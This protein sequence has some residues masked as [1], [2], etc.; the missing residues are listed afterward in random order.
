MSKLSA[1]A[2]GFVILVIEFVIAIV[3]SI[4]VLALQDYSPLIFSR[5]GYFGVLIVKQNILLFCVELLSL[6]LGTLL[7]L[8][9]L[10]E[11][12]VN[13][14]LVR[15]ALVGMIPWLI[16]LV[17]LFVLPRSDSFSTMLL[18]LAATALLFSCILVFVSLDSNRSALRSRICG[19]LLGSSLLPFGVLS[20]LRDFYN[21]FVLLTSFP[22]S[23]GYETRLAWTTR[24]FA[25]Y[26]T[27]QKGI[28]IKLKQGPDR[29][30]LHNHEAAFLKD[31]LHTII[32]DQMSWSEASASFELK[33]GR[34][35]EMCRG[36]R[37][38]CALATG[39][40]SLEEP[41]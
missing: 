11:R 25:D 12:F 31:R 1:K 17:S 9:N 28:E 34:V 30:A 29:A 33:D 26:P 40:E 35:L 39:K 41:K 20:P 18:I 23:E 5:L 8:S 7:L 38:E 22:N 24:F 10:F 14:S 15:A 37:I 3:L 4:A 2:T 36:D 13:I 21:S 32:D 27:I 6:T 16:F 19:I